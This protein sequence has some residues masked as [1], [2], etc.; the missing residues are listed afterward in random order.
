LIQPANQ[1]TTDEEIDELIDRSLI[2]F[3]HPSGTCSMGAAG[4]GVVDA[5]LRVHGISGLRVVDA[6]V[7]PTIPSANINAVVIGIAEKIAARLC[8]EYV[9]HGTTA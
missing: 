3:Y 7:M 9:T 6:S 4:E 1:P 8:G 2:T 5:E